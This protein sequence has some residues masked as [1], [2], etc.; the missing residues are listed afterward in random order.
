MQTSEVILKMNKENAFPGS[1]RLFG[2]LGL[3][4]V[5]AFSSS[6]IVVHGMG[7]GIDWVRDYVSNMANEPLSWVFVTGAFIHGWGNLA[8]TFGLRGALRPGPLRTWATLLFGLAAVGILLASMFPVDPPDQTPT[9]TGMIHRAV[10]STT[11]ISEL[12]AL[13]VFTMAFRRNRRWHQQ[14]TFSL[15]LSVSAAVA[16]MLFIIA[17][18]IDIAAGLAERIALVI[19]LVW[20]I[21]ACFQLIRP[22]KK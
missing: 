6:L 2:F 14:Q 9:I 11:F 13:F 7:T 21:W 1:V 12:A 4:G 5:L 20:E 19:L 10:A 3:L 15:I 8:L 22:G 16:M 18:Q 17:M